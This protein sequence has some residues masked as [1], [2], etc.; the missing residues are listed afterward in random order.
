MKTIYAL[1]FMLLS[2][3]AQASYMERCLYEAEVKSVG[4][5]GAL[6]ETLRTGKISKVIV[7]QLTKV[8]EDLG[9]HHGCDHNLGKLK[10]LTHRVEGRNQFE[11]RQILRLK[12]V[13]IN[14]FTPEGLM[15]SETWKLVTNR[16][17]Y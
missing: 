9:S 14:S 6:N 5:A 7:V 3:Y 12:N 16:D 1:G 10:A 15:E 11:E 8:I 2:S 4:R 17:L 13:Y